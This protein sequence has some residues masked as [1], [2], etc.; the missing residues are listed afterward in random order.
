MRCY[1]EVS[2]NHG[3]SIGEVIR[4]KFDPEIQLLIRYYNHQFHL[5][6]HE[7]EKMKKEHEKTMN[8]KQ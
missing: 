3:Y 5:E 8:K 2:R 4:G 6:H 7:Y 1:I